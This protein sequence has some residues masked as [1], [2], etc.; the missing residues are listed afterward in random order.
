MKTVNELIDQLEERRQKYEEISVDTMGVIDELRAKILPAIRESR[1][2]PRTADVSLVVQTLA[3]LYKIKLDAE[4][5]IVK[6]I[7][8]ECDLISKNNKGDSDDS[9]MVITADAVREL[10]E[11]IKNAN[12]KEDA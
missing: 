9:Q 5:K 8:K 11:K 10:A 7:E 1:N 4:E 12:R 6:S 2:L 3:Q